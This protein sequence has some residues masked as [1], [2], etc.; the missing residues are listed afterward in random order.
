MKGTP[1]NLEDMVPSSGAGVDAD[2]S[3]MLDGNA[4]EQPDHISMSND[5]TEYDSGKCKKPKLGEG[6]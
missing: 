4:T 2:S 6:F 3:G 5:L 1:K